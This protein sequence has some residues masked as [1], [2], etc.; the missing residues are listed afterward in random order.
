MKRV[1]YLTDPPGAGAERFAKFAPWIPFCFFGYTSIALATSMT[2]PFFKRM[3][4]SM[5][6]PTTTKWTTLKWRVILL[7]VGFCTLLIYNAIYFD[8]LNYFGKSLS[9]RCAETISSW[10]PR[11]NTDTKDFDSV[12][13]IVTF[14][15]SVVCAPIFFLWGVRAAILSHRSKK[16]VSRQAF[17]D[18]MSGAPQTLLFFIYTIMLFRSASFVGWGCGKDS[19]MIF[20]LTMYFFAGLPWTFFETDI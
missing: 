1:N 6:L 10:E 12:L 7:T 3:R 11:C 19:D 13:I 17:L 2:N 8:E 15:T 4:K 16:G 20:V 18:G 5:G 14:Y 9:D